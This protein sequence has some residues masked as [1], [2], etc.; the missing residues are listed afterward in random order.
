MTQ[1]ALKKFLQQTPGAIRKLEELASRGIILNEW[2]ANVMFLEERGLGKTYLSYVKAAEDVISTATEKFVIESPEY[3]D[4]D[5][6]TTN[7]KLMWFK[8]FHKFVVTFY[9]ELT[10]KTVTHDRIVLGTK[11]KCSSRNERWWS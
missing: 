8:E 11:K 6:N 2:Q 4:P 10:V 1:S 9:P 7:R 3:Y 5:A